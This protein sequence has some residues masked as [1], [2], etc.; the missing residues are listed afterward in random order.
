METHAH[1][2]DAGAHGVSAL[3]LI[4][5]GPGALSRS[6]RRRGGRGLCEARTPEI[7]MARAEILAPA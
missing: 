4:D 3:G 5:S 7:L 2:T 1:P 6:C